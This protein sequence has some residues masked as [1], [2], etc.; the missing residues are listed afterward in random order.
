[1]GVLLLYGWVRKFAPARHFVGLWLCDRSSGGC[2]RVTSAV[3]RVLSV[4]DRVWTHT[5]RTGSVHPAVGVRRLLRVP[6]RVGCPRTPRSG[7]RRGGGRGT[8]RGVIRT[9]VRAMGPDPRY[10]LAD[11]IRVSHRGEPASE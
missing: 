2:S 6:V 8:R 10:G 9:C 4:G 3:P 7:G 11:G 5:S 1:M